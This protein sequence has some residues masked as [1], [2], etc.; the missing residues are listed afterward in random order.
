MS[1]FKMKNFW[2]L[3]FNFSSLYLKW[4]SQVTLWDKTFLYLGIGSKTSVNIYAKF[5]FSLPFKV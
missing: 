1:F 3:S 4:H 5:F 2:S